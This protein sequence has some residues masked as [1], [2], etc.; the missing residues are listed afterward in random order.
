[1]PVRHLFWLFYQVLYRAAV[2]ILFNM[3]PIHS[4]GHDTY[5]H[6]YVVYISNFGPH[7]ANVTDRYRRDPYWKTSRGQG[8]LRL[9]IGVYPSHVI[10]LPPC[11]DLSTFTTSTPISTP[12]LTSSA[13]ALFIKSH[14]RSDPRRADTRMD[15]VLARTIFN[16]TSSQ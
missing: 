3:P 6:M 5:S 15:Q 4:T 7:S 16:C 10:S 8:T 11:L 14:F 9:M 2:L 13:D 1:V 12:V